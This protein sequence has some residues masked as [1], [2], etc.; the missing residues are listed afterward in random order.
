[1]TAEIRVGAPGEEPA[2][3][4]PRAPGA[5]APEAGTF[6]GRIY[7]RAHTARVFEAWA[8][9]PGLT[10]WLLS[11]AEFRAPGEATGRPDAVARSGDDFRWTW[12]AA[13]RT[14]EGR[15]L[16]AD[17]PGKLELAFDPGGPCRVS[18][19]AEGDGTVVELAHL[20]LDDPAARLDWSTAWTFFLT[21]LKSVLE[22]GA[23][24]RETDPA[25]GRTVNQ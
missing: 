24:L 18:L 5:D 4:E 23:D 20:G 15:V 12:Q 7:V 16:A 14:V 10:R 13:G 3:A 17:W 1:M 6:T 11:S 25:R 19:A 22:G 2:P 9:G 21:N 8:T